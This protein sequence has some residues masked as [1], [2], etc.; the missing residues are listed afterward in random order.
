MRINREELLRQLESVVPGLSTRE[1]IEQSSC[2]VFTDGTVNTYNDEIACIQ[3]TD[4]E[5]DG[6]V[7]AEP[8]INLLRKMTEETLEISVDKNELII[9]GKNKRAGIQMELDIL[10]PIEAVDKPKKKGWKKLP[11]EFSDAIAIVQPCAGSNE[12]QFSMTCIHITPNWIEA[13]D[14]YQASRFKMEMDIKKSTLVRKESLKHILSLGMIKFN[15][16]KHWIH[17][18]NSSGLILSCR[19][20]IEE[21]PS[22]DITKIF[23][24]HRGESLV[25]PKGLKETIEKASIFASEN[26]DGCI[27][28]ISLQKGKIVIKGKGASGWFAEQKKSKYSGKEL[29]FGIPASLLESL[30]Q[31]YNK[32]TV[33]ASRLMVKGSKFVYITTLDV[34]EKKEK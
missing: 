19:H 7:R 18:K 2:F 23:E 27:L 8:F 15:E 34:V 20:F 29:Q 10:L 6:A 5:I 17:F 28:N 26:P 11:E 30:V 12:S 13:C 4:L 22:D 32:C 33:S 21:Y 14:A 25:L 9:R 16:T 24:K 1:I 31:Q 3:K